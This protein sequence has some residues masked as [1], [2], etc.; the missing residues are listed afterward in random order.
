M[1]I[2]DILFL[3]CGILIFLGLALAW[4]IARAAGKAEEKYDR[5]RQ[6]LF[7]R[8]LRSRANGKGDYPS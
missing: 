5:A 2:G 8:Y 4:R 3:L 7:S 1:D 6:E